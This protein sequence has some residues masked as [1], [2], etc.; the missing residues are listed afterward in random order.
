MNGGIIG[1]D[2]FL[3]MSDRGLLMEPLPFIFAL[4]M[5]TESLGMPLTTGAGISKEG[6]GEL[7]EVSEGVSICRDLD[8]VVLELDRE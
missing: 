5:S 4:A 1:D 7:G 2:C 3:S 8:V 6:E